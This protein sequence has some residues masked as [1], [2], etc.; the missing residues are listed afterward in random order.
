VD[1]RR[2]HGLQLLRDHDVLKHYTTRPDL[3]DDSADKERCIPD[4]GIAVLGEVNAPCRTRERCR[5]KRIVR[6]T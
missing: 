5:L 3:I 6:A 2:R 4:A 1:R